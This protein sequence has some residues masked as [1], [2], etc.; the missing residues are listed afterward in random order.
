MPRLLVLRECAY[1]TRRLASPTR[2]ER[3]VQPMVVRADGEI[4]EGGEDLAPRAFRGNAR[5]L[6][7][8]EV[9]PAEALGCH[10]L[11][12]NLAHF[13]ASEFGFGSEQDGA[14][15]RLALAAALDHPVEI[16]TGHV[17][18]PIP[19]GEPPLVGREHDV[20]GHRL[21]DWPAPTHP[22]PPP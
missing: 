19:V 2:C 20:A 14:D 21:V 5:D 16:V 15:P 13:P 1:E 10:N 8:D 11:L 6:R 12:L 17:D 9:L 3:Q 22:L 4:M 18:R 7:D